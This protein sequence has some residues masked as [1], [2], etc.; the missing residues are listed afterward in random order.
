MNPMYDFTKNEIGLIHMGLFAIAQSTKEAMEESELEPPD[1]FV[2]T[3]E[4]VINKINEVI[5]ARIA[6]QDQFESLIT[7][8]TDV[9]NK[10]QSVISNPE[11]PINEYN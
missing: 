9:E 6:N 7:S 5:E 1:G 4:S 10:S 2:E 3:L 11:T 8:L